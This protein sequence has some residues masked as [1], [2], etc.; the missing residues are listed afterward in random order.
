MS[1]EQ[2]KAFIERMKTDK[3]FHDTIMAIEDKAK[4]LEAIKAAGYELDY[5]DILALQ[6]DP[7]ARRDI[8]D[9][10]RCRQVAC[11]GGCVRFAECGTTDWDGV[12]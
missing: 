1:A 5:D 6:I 10:M 8:H 9:L 7:L 2:A 12:R 11:E 4:R 3:E